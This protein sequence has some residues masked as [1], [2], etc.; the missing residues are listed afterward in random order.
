MAFRDFFGCWIND[1]EGVLMLCF[2]SAAAA[3]GDMV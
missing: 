2:A 1:D 3:T